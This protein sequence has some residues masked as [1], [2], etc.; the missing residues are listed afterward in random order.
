MNFDSR[1]KKNVSCQR[2]HRDTWKLIRTGSLN[3]RS[4]KNENIGR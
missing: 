4:E 2:G 3:D 1:R